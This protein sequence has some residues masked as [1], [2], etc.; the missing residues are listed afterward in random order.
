MRARSNT[1]SP[2]WS[3]STSTIRPP[4][5]ASQRISTTRCASDQK[6]IGPRRH[7]RSISAVN[8]WNAVVGSTATT[9]SDVTV[10]PSVIAGP[11]RGA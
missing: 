3:S 11:P 5:P 10:S 6:L 2:E 8:A 4:T 9:T 1:V 7:H